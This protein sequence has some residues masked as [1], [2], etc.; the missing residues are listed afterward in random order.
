MASSRQKAESRNL[1]REVV[2]RP[3]AFGQELVP[4]RRDLLL[5]VEYLLVQARSSS[6]RVESGK[7]SVRYPTA[8]AMKVIAAVAPN[9]TSTP[10]PATSGSLSIG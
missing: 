7:E 6:V 9:D 4:D 1:C 2:T 10:I 5:E 8:I 3:V